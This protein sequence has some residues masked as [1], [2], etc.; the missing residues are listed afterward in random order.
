[1]SADKSPG[2][3][4]FNGAFLKACWPI[5][6]KEFY[7]LC[8]EFHQGSLNLESLNYGLITLIPKTA[9]PETVKD[10]QIGRAHV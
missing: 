10:Y 2:P 7:D 3:D 9:S 6:K 8:D 4:G 5:I 1:M